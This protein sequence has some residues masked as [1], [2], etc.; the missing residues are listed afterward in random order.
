MS[1]ATAAYSALSLLLK[2]YIAPLARGC[3][4]AAAA[5][6]GTRGRVRRSAGR[7]ARRCTCVTTWQYCNWARCHVAPDCS[8]C[9]TGH[10]RQDTDTCHSAQRTACRA[11]GKATGRDAVHSD[12]TV[13]SCHS[14]VVLT[15]MCAEIGPRGGPGADCS[16]PSDRMKVSRTS[17]KWQ[18]ATDARRRRRAAAAHI[19]RDAEKV[20]RSECGWAPIPSAR[21]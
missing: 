10:G 8:R 15:P 4:R 17:A 1:T 16:D 21:A 3:R 2:L 19:A 12:T 11:V 9:V 7:S 14:C 13:A 6:R 5:C 20:R 18:S